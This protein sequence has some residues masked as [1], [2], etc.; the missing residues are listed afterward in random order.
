MKKVEQKNKKNTKSF[1]ICSDF[2]NLLLNLSANESK[3]LFAMRCSHEKMG[4]IDGLI[5]SV[6][7]ADLFFA[8]F[9]ARFERDSEK[10][11]RF[12]IESA[13]NKTQ[14]NPKKP[15]GFLKNPKKPIIRIII[16]ITIIIKIIL[17]IKI[18]ISTLRRTCAPA[19]LQKER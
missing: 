18:T 2:Q 3:I 14:N 7:D 19:L 6:P 12:C 11:G 5:K 8:K 15:N 1:A 17:I 10:Y 9:C 4:E 16:K 13:K